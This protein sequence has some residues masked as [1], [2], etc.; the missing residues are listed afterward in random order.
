MGRYN[1]NPTAIDDGV[2]DDEDATAM[3]EE[4]FEEAKHCKWVKNDYIVKIQYTTNKNA[5]AI[6]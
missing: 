1:N 2:K 6:K 4:E 3:E 5:I